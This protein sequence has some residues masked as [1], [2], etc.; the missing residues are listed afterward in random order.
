M[1]WS[2]MEC[3]V[4]ILDTV[5]FTYSRYMIPTNSEFIQNHLILVSCLNW[6]DC[7]KTS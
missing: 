6:L 1:G 7:S 5:L 3:T 2:R 4:S